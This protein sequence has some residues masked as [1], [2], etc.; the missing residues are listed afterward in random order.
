MRCEDEIAGYCA[1]KIK[2]KK[3][4]EILGCNKCCLRC[5][6]KCDEVCGE[7]GADDKCINT[8]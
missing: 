8:Q 1:K 4:T 6:N 7:I 2:Y 3:Y 5:K